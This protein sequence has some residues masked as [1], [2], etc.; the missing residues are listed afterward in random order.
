MINFSYHVNLTLLAITKLL[1]TRFSYY[2]HET[3]MH[4]YSIIIY[5]NPYFSSNACLVACCKY[6]CLFRDVSISS[7]YCHF[8]HHH[9]TYIYLQPHQLTC[10]EESTSFSSH[11]DDFDDTH[12]LIIWHTACSASLFYTS[13]MVSSPSLVSISFKRGRI[14]RLRTAVTNGN[15]KFWRWMNLILRQACIFNIMLITCTRLQWPTP[16]INVL[17]SISILLALLVKSSKFSW[18][19]L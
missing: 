10:L 17:R 12:N 3:E 5:L 2:L 8:H 19:N 1:F 9:H 11:Y 4:T 16:N 13:S 14:K 6:C 18:E 15:D 7:S